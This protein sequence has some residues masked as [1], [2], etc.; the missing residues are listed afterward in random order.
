MSGI[1]SVAIDQCVLFYKNHRIYIN[2]VVLAKGLV[3][4]SDEDSIGREGEADC[5]AA[6]RRLL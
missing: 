1:E 6:A 3:L 4:S 2:A 5:A